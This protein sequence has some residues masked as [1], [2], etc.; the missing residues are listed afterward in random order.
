MRVWPSRYRVGT[1][2]PKVGNFEVPWVRLPIPFLSISKFP[3]VKSR[4][5]TRFMWQFAI[6]ES[7]PNIIFWVILPKTLI[8][9]G[10]KYTDG[11]RDW[12]RPLRSRSQYSNTKYRSFWSM[13]TS[14]SL[15][16]RGTLRN[17]VFVVDFSKYWYLS[18][19]GARK[20]LVI[21]LDQHFFES[22]RVIRP[23]IDSLI[24]LTISSPAN[25]LFLFIV[26]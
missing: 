25:N 17:Y 18:N 16:W 14:Y 3:G 11:P 1:S 8:L 12:I 4:C 9:W 24:D 19:W 6:P 2:E 7:R 13:T 20:T 15:S 26:G 5:I 23:F 22:Y 21:H 10:S